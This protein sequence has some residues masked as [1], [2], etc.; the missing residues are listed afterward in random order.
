MSI[1]SATSSGDLRRI[2]SISSSERSSR[3]GCEDLR[4][5]SRDSVSS[6]LAGESSVIIRTARY[7]PG[8]RR[9]AREARQPSC[10]RGRAQ[11]RYAVDPL[12]AALHGRGGDRPDRVLVTVYDDLRELIV[13]GQFYQSAVVT[14]SALAQR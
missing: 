2:T 3:R 4:V 8:G 11:H 13:S 9:S 1:S 12:H 6:D 10:R 7:C 5:G 14:E